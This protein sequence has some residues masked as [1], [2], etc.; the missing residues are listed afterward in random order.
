MTSAS[1]ARWSTSHVYGFE[2]YAS[3]SPRPTRRRTIVPRVYIGSTTLAILLVGVM[4]CMAILS[5]LH[6]NR[7]ATRGYE[8][9]AVQSRHEELANEAKVLRMRVAE[10]Q[11][12]KHLDATTGLVAAGSI[13]RVRVDHRVALK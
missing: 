5:L 4:C 6:S 1:Q 9:R 2:K 8:L 7:A 10:L 3:S 13:D 11:A 12:L